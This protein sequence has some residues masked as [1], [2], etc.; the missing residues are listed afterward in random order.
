MRPRGSP[1]GAQPRTPA[2]RG[3]SV[4]RTRSGTQSRRGSSTAQNQSP[5]KRLGRVRAGSTRRWRRGHMERTRRRDQRFGAGISNLALEKCLSMGNP[6]GYEHSTGSKMPGRVNP[7]VAEARVAPDPSRARAGENPR[8]DLRAPGG[9]AS[10]SYDA[11]FLSKAVGGTSGPGASPSREILPCSKVWSAASS[12]AMAIQ[13]TAP[14]R[15]SPQAI[16]I[17]YSASG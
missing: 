17:V 11:G 8:D 5:P 7:H 15:S 14:L 6:A 3:H 2:F 10:S 16:S 12:L 13:Q 4:L 1:D 9:A